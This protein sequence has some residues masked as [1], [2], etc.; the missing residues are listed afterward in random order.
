MLFL[1]PYL[2]I[3]PMTY[4]IV[5]FLQSWIKLAHK[6]KDPN[7]NEEGTVRGIGEEYLKE[8][9]KLQIRFLV[10]EAVLGLILYI[11]LEAT[12]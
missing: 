7:H 5:Y 10:I 12:Y 8:V 6:Y 11:S 4:N 2:L 3:I 1:I 9:K